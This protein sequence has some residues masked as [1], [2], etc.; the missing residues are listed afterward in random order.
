MRGAAKCA[1]NEAA[2]VQAEAETSAAERTEASERESGLTDVD[3]GRDVLTVEVNRREA[4]RPG[5]GEKRRRVGRREKKT[6]FL[7][8]RAEAE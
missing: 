6:A 4:L 1:S 7:G 8:D 3:S 5:H 2:S